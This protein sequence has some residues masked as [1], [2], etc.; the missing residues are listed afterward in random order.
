MLAVVATLTA[1]EKAEDRAAAASEAK[2]DARYCLASGRDSPIHMPPSGCL[3]SA[4][5]AYVLAMTPAGSLGILALGSDGALG[6]LVWTSGSKAKQPYGASMTFQG[7]GNLV[8]YDGEQAIWNAGAVGPIGTYDLTLTDDGNLVIRDRVGRAIWSTHFDVQLCAKKLQAP[9]QMTSGS[10]LA[11]PSRT[12]VMVLTPGGALNVAPVV[13]GVLGKPVWTSGAA[14]PS[15]AHL[16]IAVQADGNLVVYDGL[17]PIWNSQTAGASGTIRLELDDQGV[18]IL[19]GSGDAVLWSSK[20][21]R[22]AFIPPRSHS[23]A[24]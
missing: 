24:L 23:R 14:D 3:I 9:E 7:D 18:L 6:R 12:F 19:H 13:G 4:N 21:G 20:S 5:K 11:S 22:T 2:F 1:C 15:P 16:F 17:R 8:V 10:C